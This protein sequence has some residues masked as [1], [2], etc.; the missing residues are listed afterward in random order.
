MNGHIVSPVIFLFFASLS[1]WRE[2]IWG[3][4]VSICLQIA[5]VTSGEAARAAERASGRHSRNLSTA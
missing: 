1:P 4:V 3:I 5:R 2:G